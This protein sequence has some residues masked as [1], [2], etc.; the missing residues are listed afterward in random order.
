M[1]R[2]SYIKS[3]G[4]EELARIPPA[5]AADAILEAADTFLAHIEGVQWVRP[6]G[7]L[8]VWLRLPEG[9]DTGLSGPLFDRAVAEGVLYV[10]GEYCYPSEGRPVPKNVVRLSF[11]IQSCESIHKGMEAL[12][13]AVHQVI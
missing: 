12:G 6:T 8:Y 4:K 2:F 1:T 13:R 7:G 11:G 10:P 9:I 5:F 3:A